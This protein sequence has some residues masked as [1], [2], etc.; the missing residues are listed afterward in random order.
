MVRIKL[1]GWLGLCGLGLLLAGCAHRAPTFSPTAVPD[2]KS[3]IF[4]GRFTMGHDWALHNELALWLQNV[5]SRKNLYV[6]F[7]PDQPVYAVPAAAGRYRIAG[8]VG[9]NRVHEIEVRHE[10]RSSQTA[11]VVAP[12]TAPARTPVYLG[13][14][15]G[16]ATFDGAVMEWRVNSG[17]NNFT[18][19]T[20]EFRKEYPNLGSAPATSRWRL[21]PDRP[22]ASEHRP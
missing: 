9:V 4:Y 19:T 2:A 15:M 12:F 6:Y 13:D 7:D 8:F 1:A 3:T 11:M 5:E 17:T 22:G 16:Q 10:F 20:A 14:F 21:L 18:A